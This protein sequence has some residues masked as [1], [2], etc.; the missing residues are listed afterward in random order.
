MF[1]IRILSQE[2]IKPIVS[3]KD[4]VDAVEQVYCLKAE[5]K[6]SIWPLVTYDFEVGVSDMDIKSGYIGGLNIFGMKSVSYFS[7][8]AKAGL[9][10]LIGILT[11][12]NAENGAPLGIMDAGY[13]TC[14]RTGAAGALG[15]KYLARKDASKMTMIGAGKQALFQMAAALTVRPEIEKISI[16]DGLSEK[17]AKDV[18]DNAVKLLG[19][20]NVNAAN[21]CFEAVSDLEKTVRDSDIIVTATP[22]RKPIVMNEWVKAGTHFSCVGSDVS[23]K[24]EI[25]ENILTR[26]KI[27][28]DDKAQCVNVGEIE[29]GIKKNVISEN[30]IRGEIGEVILGKKQGRISDDDIT[31]Y[32]TTGIAIQDLVTAKKVLDIAEKENIGTIVEI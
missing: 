28:V 7:N 6:T 16:Y 1:N 29:I 4:A 13:I 32:D 25:D 30:D 22:S 27:Y 8:N 19:E 9:P 3:V 17:N 14:L 23:G 18:A 26:T 10:N 11:V 24:Q 5:G 31:L 21:V 2:Q 12:Y 20:L 15:I